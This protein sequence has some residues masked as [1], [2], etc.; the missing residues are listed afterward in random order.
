MSSRYGPW[1]TSID[2]G[3]NPQLSAFWRRRLVMLVPASRT[4]PTLSLRSL[5]WLGVTA[6]IL[7]ALPTFRNLPAVAAEEQPG[8]A[9]KKSSDG[10]PV[11][12]RPVLRED[13]CSI[14]PRPFYCNTKDAELVAK[15][16]LMPEQCKQLRAVAEKAYDQWTQASNEDHEKLQQ[17]IKKIEALP[18]EDR[19]GKYKALSAADKR[20]RAERDQQHKKNTRKAVEALLT[21]QQL[22][23]VKDLAYPELVFANLHDAKTLDEIGLSD[24]QK[25]KVR[26]LCLETSRKHQQAAFDRAATWPGILTPE[27]R[28]KLRNEAQR[29]IDKR[30][31]EREAGRRFYCG[32]TNLLAALQ[33]GDEDCFPAYPEIACRLVRK[34]LQVTDGQELRLREVVAKTWARESELMKALA[35]Q[36]SADG[37]DF[38]ARQEKMLAELFKENRRQIDDI[39]APQQLSALK[40]FVLV[41][42]MAV[43]LFDSDRLAAI[44]ATD[45]QRAKLRQM[46]DEADKEGSLVFEQASRQALK[47]L[48]PRQHELFREKFDRDGWW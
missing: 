30:V 45:Q 37:A 4:S 31:A 24:Q 13:Y 21:P 27:Q 11:V 12:S 29:R 17:L 5:F 33:I 43:L 46:F 1:A 22:Q 19:E 36:G 42:E 25:D 15:I 8:A 14:Y 3:E 26:D 16:G 34:R 35:K 6:A 41:R 38:N 47:L 2:V 44:G 48:T 40:E 32:S 20:R 9:E 7:V 39:L 18:K 23:K 10:R 28:D